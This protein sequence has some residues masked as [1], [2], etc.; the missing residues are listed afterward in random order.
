VLDEYHY[1]MLGNIVATEVGSV[2]G[3]G[4]TMMIVSVKYCLKVWEASGRG[5]GTIFL[6]K[7][8]V[9]LFL[10]CISPGILAT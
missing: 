10:D 5:N 9:K 3:W 7:N 6:W 8:H 2:S 1:E 4:D